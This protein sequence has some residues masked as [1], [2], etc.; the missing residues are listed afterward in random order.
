MGRVFV[1]AKG[2]L[3]GGHRPQVAKAMTGSCRHGLLRVRERGRATE[4]RLQQG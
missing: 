1:N 4:A 3:V 2:L